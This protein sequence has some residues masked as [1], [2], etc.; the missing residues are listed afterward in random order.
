[1]IV[2]LLISFLQLTSFPSG[3]FC[4]PWQAQTD[5]FFNFYFFA[6]A[7]FGDFPKKK[8]FFNFFIFEVE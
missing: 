4:G 2:L 1:M 5:A 8:F 6:S 7:T 3:A